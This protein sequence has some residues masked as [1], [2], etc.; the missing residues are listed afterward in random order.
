MKRVARVS[1]KEAVIA[2]LEDYITDNHL[3]PGDSLPTEQ[4][5]SRRLNVSRT[6]LREGLQYFRTLGIIGTKPK[7]GAH[8]KSLSPENPFGCYLR[9]MS[10][11]KRKI[12]EIGQMRMI[13]E[14]GMA[15]FLVEMAGEDDFNRLES[16]ANGMRDASDA[17]R[18]SLDVEFH[19]GM[20]KIVRNE[21]MSGL[22]PLIIDFFE[23]A[24]DSLCGA[25]G[26]SPAKIAE[27]HLDMVE[28]MRKGSPDELSKLIRAHYAS[29]LKKARRGCGTEESR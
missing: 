23:K 12:A 8:I 11:N 29:Y 28:A 9:F 4:E 27:E 18:R 3:G 24:N 15:S 19:S 25:I 1:A 22:I 21:L 14:L 7:S 16:L 6:V 26:K 10:G 13:I 5:L 17:R 20:L 2:A